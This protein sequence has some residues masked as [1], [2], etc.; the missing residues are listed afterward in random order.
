MRKRRL[1]PLPLEMGPRN[2]RQG[3]KK[4]RDLHRGHGGHRG[5]IKVVCT[6]P[7][8]NF[9]LSLKI[10]LCDLCVSQFPQFRRQRLEPWLTWNRWPPRTPEISEMEPAKHAKRREKIKRLTPRSRG[11]QRRYQSART[12]PA[13]NF[14]LSLKIIPCDLCVSLPFTPFASFRVFRGPISSSGSAPDGGGQDGGG[15]STN[16]PHNSVADPPRFRKTLTPSSECGR[17]S[18]LVRSTNSASL[19]NADFCTRVPCA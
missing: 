13:P 17:D 16:L 3:A 9:S 7:A 4:L 10:I 1:Q 2:T 18:K 8:P 5:N 19:G 12:P 11:S 6:R 14:S 15:Q